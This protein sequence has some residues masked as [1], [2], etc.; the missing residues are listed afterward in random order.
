MPVSFSFQTHLD[1]QW[2]LNPPL[3]HLPL[4]SVPPSLGTVT[5][6][7]G[8]QERGKFPLF[9]S[10]KPSQPSPDN[11]QT[12]L[13]QFTSCR[14]Q[15][16][17]GP[18]LSLGHHRPPPAP[19]PAVLGAEPPWFL[20][21][22]LQDCARNAELGMDRQQQCGDK[23]QTFVPSVPSQG[24]LCTPVSPCP[25]S[26]PGL[27]SVEGTQLFQEGLNAWGIPRDH[28]HPSKS[29]VSVLAGGFSPSQELQAVG[30]FRV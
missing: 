21:I 9:Q 7:F 23:S 1:N 30:Q 28:I 19:N 13:R 20:G 15:T 2:W 14:T 11:F 29:R 26:L 10:H 12:I 16:S 6:P 22:T 17:A 3:C 18:L 25:V 4:H 5:K 8:S 27:C 24:H